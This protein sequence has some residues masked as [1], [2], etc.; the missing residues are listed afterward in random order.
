MTSSVEAM[1]ESC[2]GCDAVISAVGFVPGSPF[3]MQKEAHAV[4]N[5]GT[6]ALI[7]ACVKVSR[8]AK[9]NI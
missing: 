5:V 8:H 7:D 1:A 2:K 4:D 9:V 3:N 6:I